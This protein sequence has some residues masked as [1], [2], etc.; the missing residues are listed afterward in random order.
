MGY[1]GVTLTQV[2][3]RV[4]GANVSLRDVTIAQM[5]NGASKC[6]WRRTPEARG[7]F[8]DFEKIQLPELRPVSGEDGWLSLARGGIGLVSHAMG[9]DE[10]AIIER[11]CISSK[12]L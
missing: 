9:A 8:W 3:T 7:G 6:E 5:G 1:L 4:H 2:F 12:N 11:M 10:K